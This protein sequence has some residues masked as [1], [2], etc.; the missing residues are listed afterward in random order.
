[1]KRIIPA[2]LP[3]VI[4]ALALGLAA[5]IV[6][7]GVVLIDSIRVA[8]TPTVIAATA[9]DSSQTIII[10]ATPTTDSALL[11]SPVETAIYVVPTLNTPIT[12]T[13]VNPT[14]VPSGGA[15]QVAT[16]TPTAAP[17]RGLRVSSPGGLLPRE[18]GG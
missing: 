5:W 3:V 16:H 6:V 2:R 7:G 1:M 18:D 11:P 12:P 17:P 4:G 9:T 10:T 13:L 15:R 14:A 8:R